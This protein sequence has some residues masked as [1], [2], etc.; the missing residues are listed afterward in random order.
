MLQ[1]ELQMIQ[2]ELIRSSTS[3]DRSQNAIQSIKANVTEHESKLRYANDIII[4]VESENY[5][6]EMEIAAATATIDAQ[7]R[8]YN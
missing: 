1:R 7:N 5:E 2:E 4:S 6:I 8:A 3:Y